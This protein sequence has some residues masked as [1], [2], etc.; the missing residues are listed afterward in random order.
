MFT[1]ETLS[2][3]DIQ[4]VHNIKEEQVMTILEEEKN[5]LNRVHAD[6][7]MA[8]DRDGINKVYRQARVWTRF[9]HFLAQACSYQKYQYLNNKFKHYRWDALASIK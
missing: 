4:T 3:A 9:H 8:I 7:N 5:I 6:M 1:V 2:T